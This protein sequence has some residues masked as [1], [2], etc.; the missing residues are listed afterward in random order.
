MTRAILLSQDI[1]ST[2]HTLAVNMAKLIHADDC[3]IARWDEERKT[4]IPVAATSSIEGSYPSYRDTRSEDL[5]MALAVLDVRH[6]LVAD[7]AYDSPFV[8][9][10][11]SKKLGV[12]SGLGIPLIA[13]EH[14][15]GAA[16]I[17]FKTPHRFTPE[18]IER[19]EQAG[20]QIALALWNFQQ[21]V[22][23]QQRLRES[24]TLAKIERTLSET[25]HVGTGEVLQL[26]VDS[27]R[28]LMPHAQ[29]SVIHLL[30]AKENVLFAR[31]VS[32]YDAQEK[33]NTRLR[34]RLGEGLL[35]KSSGKVFRSMWQHP[36]L[37]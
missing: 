1:D 32:G 25:E 29:K 33:E 36:S 23:I 16:I 2:L 22:E 20:N 17:A 26:I 28:E 10:D 21:S 27:A 14:K 15:L 6:A 3:Y 37:S 31:A 13:G 11:L 30:E 19:A 34:M 4:V 12:R 24:T 5:K 18:E 7:D 8:N 9:V 35:A